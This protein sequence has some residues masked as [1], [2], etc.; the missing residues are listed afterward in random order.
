MSE[1]FKNPTINKNEINH[2]NSNLE[3]FNNLA[4]DG[5]ISSYV[6]AAIC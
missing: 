6:I 2:L 1:A 4:H 5:Y 3:D